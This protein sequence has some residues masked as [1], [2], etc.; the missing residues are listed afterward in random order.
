MTNKIKLGVIADDFTGASDAASFLTK[1]G[2]RT[3]LCTAGSSASIDEETEAV[4]IAL[5]TRTQETASAIKEVM[6]SVRWLQELGAEYYYSKFCSTFDSTPEGN[7]G[8]IL[9]RLLEYFDE[10]Y[11]ILA[12]SLPINGRKVEDGHLYV[13]GVPLH[14]SSMKDHPL[15]PMW[16]SD[17][18]ELMKDQSKYPVFTIRRTDLMDDNW[19]KTKEKIESLIDS[20]THFYLVPDFVDDED[21]KLIAQRF[22]D[23][24]VLGGGSGLLEFTGKHF[25]ANRDI[26]EGKSLPIHTEGAPILVAGSS[27]EQTLRQISAYEEK[28]GLS[29][30]VYP[31]QLDEGTQSIE[32]IMSW[33]NE[34]REKP[35][36]IYVS[37]SKEERENTRYIPNLAQILEDLLADIVN[38]EVNV[39]RKGVIVAGGETSGAVIK[40]LALNSFIVSKSVAP[41]VPVLIP[42]E[43]KELRIV[44]KSGNFG[45]ND[46]FERAI[47]MIEEGSNYDE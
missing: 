13:N 28:G 7:I 3:V 16:T 15:T 11:S 44:L 43:D 1:A 10:P 40:R 9:D 29:Y 45:G 6:D 37:A 24:K 39:G 21:G 26:K 36:L 27:S 17:I 38:K 12:P 42:V 2:M 5:K 31:E 8:P 20:H 30:K 23:L 18:A 19:S 35:V 34:N 25:I 14:K 32:K 22:S 47:R 41:G 33:V 4:V 46:F